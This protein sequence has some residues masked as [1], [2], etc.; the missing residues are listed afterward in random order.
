MVI[1]IKSWQLPL[2]RLWF[3]KIKYKMFL[4]RPLGVSHLKRIVLLSVAQIGIG[5]SV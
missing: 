4:S 5:V 1:E 3:Y 2:L